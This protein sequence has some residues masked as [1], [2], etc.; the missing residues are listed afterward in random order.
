MPEIFPAHW[1]Q[2]LEFLKIVT[3]YWPVH[4]AERGLLAPMERRNRLILAEAGGSRRRRRTAPVIIAG[5]TGSIPA[6]AELMRAVA[7]G[8]GA[9]SC[10]RHSTRGSTMRVSTASST[11]AHPE[12]PQFGFRNLLTRLGVARADVRE[13][14]GATL[15]ARAPHRNRLI[16]EA[17]AAGRLDG[18]LAHVHRRDEPRPRSRPALAGVS[19]IEAPIGG[20][21]GRG[22][23]ADPARGGRDAG[24][25][26]GA[27]L[28][29]PA[30]GA[31]RRDPTRKLGHPRRRFGRPAVRQDDARR[32]PRSGRQCRAQPAL[33]RPN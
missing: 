14:P 26:G 19:L 20:G 9:R 23:R 24:A 27:G 3:E 28:A 21:R 30:A 22:G 16:S 13:L 29:R 18:A 5:V 12:H 17:H 4:L 1:Q 15:D 10:C 2:T 33:R 31:P 6:T 7:G 8:A 11:T 25:H 32:V